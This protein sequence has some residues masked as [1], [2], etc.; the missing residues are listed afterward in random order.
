[1]WSWRSS[2]TLVVGG[3][4]VVFVVGCVLPVA[5]L[6]TTSLVGIEGAIRALWL[7]ARQRMLL[8]NT[9][10]L[11]V[12]AAALSTTI[13]A[14]LGITLARVPL[15]WKGGLRVVLA[16]P[17]LLP[18]YVLAL[19]W[20]YLG[21]GAS[22]TYTLPA[23]IGVMSLVFYPLPMLASE[24]AFRR[25]DARLEEAALAVAP[26]RLVLRRIMLPL[27]AP[28][29]ASA[30]LIVFVL[31]ISDFGVPGLLRVRVYTTEVFTAFAALYDYSRAI[32]LA[33][34]LLVLCAGVGAVAAGM[35]GGRFV[36]PRR[37]TGGH[38]PLFDRW[39]RR[40][41]VGIAVV[42]VI[43]VALPILV[44]AREALNSRALL[45]LFDG[46]GE[47][48][49][50]SVILSAIGAILVVVVAAVLGYARA[51]ASARVASFTDVLFVVIFAVPSTIV[52]VG[53]IGV[54]NRPGPL[55][56]VYGTN[57]MFIL[58]YLARFV[59]V[60]ALILA[61]AVRYVP[62]SHEEAAAAA[63]AGWFRT[64]HRILLPQLRLG[65][66]AT[67]AVVFVLSFGELGASVLIAPPGEATL[68]IRVY[69]MIANAPPADVAALALLQ[70]AVVLTP[71]AMVAAVAS[72][73][74][75]RL[76]DR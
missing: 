56:T 12:G 48:V 60:A 34:P 44:L 61:G 3:A 65:L 67:W 18:P 71:L 31:A 54:W 14:P 42:I 13:G 62:I 5:Y 23:A 11:G 17:M 40:A 68:P 51:R 29:V 47:A 69:T 24:L 22:F 9:T 1:M 57:V 43:A 2:R 63:G 35:L 70:T 26:R 73:R 15:R 58:A 41:R 49:A 19:A 36:S 37:V 4:G 59:P 32:L 55:G 6:F 25:I 45:A 27:A 8:Y 30:A 20:T 39:G 16:A 7:D 10:L 74:G 33:I 46:S 72:C 38:P 53:L 75:A 76:E 28:V 52:G 66:A 64:V 50:N 21:S